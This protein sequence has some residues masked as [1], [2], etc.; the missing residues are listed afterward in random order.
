MDN[1]ADDTDNAGN[2]ATNV[3]ADPAPRRRGRPPAFDREGG[4]ETA[5]GLF[6]ARGYDGVGTAELCGAI[7]VRP[8]SLYA[9]YGS[10]LGLFEAALE[11]YAASPMATFVAEAGANATTP[12]ELA[13][14]VLRAAAERYGADPERRGC[15]A[16][17]MSIAPGD[18]EARRRA[19]RLVEQ[20]RSHLA[21][22]L[23]EL[24]APHPNEMAATI[25]TVMRGLS[26]AARAGEDRAT[27]ANTADGLAKAVTA[28]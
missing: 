9:A 2:A 25:L 19:E 17:E 23:R 18:A 15:L 3:P 10:K 13:T 26:A 16:L 6:H 20:T 1:I 14:S 22:R 4:V 5:L 27:L 7:G 12:G 8:P 24:D 28:S 21:A 11:R